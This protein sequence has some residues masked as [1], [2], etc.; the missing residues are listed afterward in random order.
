MVSTRWLL[1]LTVGLGGCLVEF[2]DSPEI[3]GRLEQGGKGLE[4]IRVT[5]VARHGER[6]GC[7][8]PGAA[9]ATTDADGRFHFPRVTHTQRVIPYGDP[10]DQWRLCFALKEGTASWG[11]SR[12]GAARRAVVTCTPEPGAHATDSQ[13][14]G[15]GVRC[16]VRDQRPSP[17]DPAA[18]K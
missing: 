2:Q 15:E 1:L 6:S 18:K 16:S 5:R 17:P 8:L 12:I 9:V 10:A 13:G 4:G 11:R 14:R 7:D 3:Q